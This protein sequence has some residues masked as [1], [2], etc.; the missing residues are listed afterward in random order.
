VFTQQ[1]HKDYKQELWQIGSLYKFQLAHC[2]Q[3]ANWELVFS[4]N[5]LLVRLRVFLPPPQSFPQQTA[6]AKLDEQSKLLT[7]NTA[8]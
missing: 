1:C 7:N 4:E 8:N 5:Y 3:A 2:V 6:F